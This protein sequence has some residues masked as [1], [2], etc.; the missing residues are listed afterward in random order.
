MALGADPVLPQGGFWLPLPRF[1]RLILTGA[2][3][4]L[5]VWWQVQVTLWAWHKRRIYYNDPQC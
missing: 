3:R 2:W 1:G 5:K 4:S